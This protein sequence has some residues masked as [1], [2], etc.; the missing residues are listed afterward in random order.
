MEK[1][2]AAKHPHIDFFSLATTVPGSSE[3]SHAF[4]EKKDI[5]YLKTEICL[6]SRIE[7]ISWSCIMGP[8]DWEKLSLFAM[9]VLVLPLSR[10]V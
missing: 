10:F 6:Q 7:F 5:S 2:F 9:N 3:K 4:A 8:V 1:A